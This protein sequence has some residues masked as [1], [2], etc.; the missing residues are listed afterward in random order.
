MPFFNRSPTDFALKIDPR[1]LKK[2]FNSIG[3]ISILL[4]S[5][6][7]KITSLLDVIVLPVWLRFRLQNPRK[8]RLGGVLGRLEG[9][10]G[11]SWSVSGVSWNVLDASWGILERLGAVLELSWS[12]WGRF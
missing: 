4:L 1:S 7:F 2:T 5:R 11:V 8:S 3:K 10:L 6:Y 12:I 9:V